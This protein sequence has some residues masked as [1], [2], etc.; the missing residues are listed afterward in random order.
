MSSAVI[1]ALRV[2]L[3][4]DT[5]Q[6]IESLKGVRAN[7]QRVGKDMQAWGGKLSTY[8]TAPISIAGA[9]VTAAVT[10]MGRDVEQ[11]SRAAQVAN[12]G[13]EE[14]QRLTY[15]ARS[16]GIESDKLADIYKDV[17]DRV[18]DFIQTGGGPMADFFE[19]IAPQV[20]VTADQFARL[21]GP[22]ALQLFYHSLE[23]A[24][25][26]QADMTFYLEAMASDTTALIPLLRN[27]GEAFRELGAG[28]AVLSE[29]DA[30]SLQQYNDAM[31]GMGEAIKS[32]TIALV[33]TGVLET[34]TSLVQKATEWTS[35]LAKTNPEIIRFTAIAA[36]IAAAIGP[37][38]VGLG[39]MATLLAGISAPILAVSAAVTALATAWV[40]WDDIKST[41]PA[42]AAAIESALSLVGQNFTLLM[43]NVGLFTTWFGQVFTGDLRAAGE[44]VQQIIS[45]IAEMIANV[46]NA[47]PAQMVD[48]GANIMGGLLSGLQASW[49]NVKAWFSGLGESIP[50]WVRDK[51]GIRSP[52]RV[53]A[54][55]GGHVMSGLGQG[56]EAGANS[57][58]GVATTIA[59]TVASAFQ[60]LIDGSKKVKDVIK[61]LLG[62]LGQMWINEGFQALIGGLS[63]GGGGGKG[64]GIFGGLFSGIGKLFGGFFAD[65]GRLG[66]GKWGIAGE[67]GPEIIKG[68]ANVVPMNEMVKPGGGGGGNSVS[69]TQNFSMTGVLSGED[70]VRIAN[71]AGREAY[72]RVKEAFPGWQF[73][74][75]TYGRP[76]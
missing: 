3:G 41:F 72:E 12:T 37:A 42:A 63:G 5:A 66:A 67:F 68:P 30:G 6:F 64:S 58:E 11:L 61:D 62:Q 51:L 47:L 49:Q 16:V 74:V 7:M 13:F 8:V 22:E 57:V 4:I 48:I 39:L 26:S 55:I 54:E 53:M 36:G 40:F 44:T 43:E 56:L 17:N 28:A 33:N 15:A 14:F 75:Q 20:G 34:L 25:L 70:A 18:G 21:S 35:A 73:D 31:R 24:N 1:G 29:Q 60:G 19:K 38:L 76:A 71:N 52:S 9:A 46:F 10:N 69:I 45:N 23:K 2:N 27:G 65:G 59:S 32:L 50:Q